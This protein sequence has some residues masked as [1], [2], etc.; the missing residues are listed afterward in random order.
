VFD[1]DLEDQTQCEWY[2]DVPT[3]HHTVIEG[4]GV[5]YE[6]LEQKM[7]DKM[8][9]QFCQKLGF[10]IVTQVAHNFTPHGKSTVFVLE[11][12]HVAA[13]TWPEKEYV[14][15]DLVTCSKNE[16]DSKKLASEFNKIFSPKQTRLLRLRY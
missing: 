11:E 13:H 2:T 8:L 9:E 3:L 16:P 14:H 12:S 4:I 6:K 5:R 15:V 10:S 7:F 1:L